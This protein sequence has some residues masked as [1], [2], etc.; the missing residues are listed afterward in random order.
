MMLYDI[1]QLNRALFDRRK[2]GIRGNDMLVAPVMIASEDG[3]M[4]KPDFS[5]VGEV[6]TRP[7][8]HRTGAN[9]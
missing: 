8:V 9:K 4:F 7:S 2:L 3:T 5:Q 6:K 1:G